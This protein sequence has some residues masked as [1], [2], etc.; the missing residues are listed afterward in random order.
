MFMKRFVVIIL[1]MVCLAGRA[2]GV[3]C[4]R[5]KGHLVCEGDGESVLIEKCGH[6]DHIEDRGVLKIRL[7][8]GGYMY[9]PVRVFYYNCGSNR[10]VQFIT[11]TGGVVT[12][13]KSGDYGTGTVRCN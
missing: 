7:E 3:D 1:I 5:C 12:H 11:I 10:L 9:K 13:I 6:P 4:I 2:W 8:Y